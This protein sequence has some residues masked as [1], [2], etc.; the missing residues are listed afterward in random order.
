MQALNELVETAASAIDAAVDM[1]ALD[2]VRVTYLGKKGELTARAKSV[3]TLPC[4]RA[5]RRPARK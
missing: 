2:E 1:A 4:Q 5:S 3:S